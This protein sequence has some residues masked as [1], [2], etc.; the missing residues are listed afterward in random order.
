MTAG[1]EYLRAGDIVRV[2]GM[3]LRTVRRWIA[4]EIL[5]STKLG[6]ARLVARADLERL[7]FSPPTQ[8]AESEESAKEHDRDSRQ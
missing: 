2:T 5:P 7:L 8:A 4:G 1:T 6:G 3:S